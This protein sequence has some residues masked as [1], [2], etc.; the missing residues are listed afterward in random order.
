MRSRHV[1]SSSS[2]VINSPLKSTD[3][4]RN[5][6]FRQSKTSWASKKVC[7]CLT[8]VWPNT[9][10]KYSQVLG[11]PHR[12]HSRTNS[13]H[14]RHLG[15]CVQDYH[16]QLLESLRERNVPFG[17][18]CWLRFGVGF[19]ST[20]FTQ[21]RHVVMSIFLLLMFSSW[22]HIFRGTLCSA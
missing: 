7:K 6:V 5:L 11:L 15:H 4:R 16:R 9:T 17:R 1:I 18:R 3:P 19:I 22:R 12:R 20:T 2:T 13:R 10:D 21:A 8:S 14:A